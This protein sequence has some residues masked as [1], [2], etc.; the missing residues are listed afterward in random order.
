MI[1]L[2]TLEQATEQEVF[3]HIAKHLLT[4][5]KQATSKRGC[6]YRT[7]EGLTCAAGCL[8]SEKEYHQLASKDSPMFEGEDWHGVVESN[9]EVTNAHEKLIKRFQLIH[10]SHDVGFWEKSIKTL[11]E[12]YNLTFNPPQP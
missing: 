8:I 12:E 6:S 5:R 1:T 3:D 9:E 7:P 11:A 4:Q 10:D 2:A